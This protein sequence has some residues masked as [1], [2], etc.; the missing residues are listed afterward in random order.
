M[1]SEIV[2]QSQPLTT[3]EILALTLYDIEAVRFGRFKLQNGKRMPI[4]LD[5]RVLV[6]YPNALN[7]VAEAYAHVIQTLTF[8]LLAAYPYAGLPIGVAVSLKMGQPLIYPRK[9][10]K[11]YGTGKQVEGVW[12]VGQQVVLIED[13]ITSGKSILEAIAT[14][15]AAGLQVKHAVVLI[16]REEDGVKSLSALGYQV[17][18]I[19][20]I[21][22]LL[23]ILEAHERISTQRRVGVL[24]ALGL[25][26]V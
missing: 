11:N 22:R 20:T 3:L 26:F 8:D 21:S 12:T 16:D 14:L 1:T 10:G 15:K 4:S 23:A 5:L 6:S 24:R 2:D 19:M 7:T 18:S 13:L 9:S 25:G 17:H